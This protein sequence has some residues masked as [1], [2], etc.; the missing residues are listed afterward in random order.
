MHLRW[1]TAAGLGPSHC[2]RGE[3]TSVSVWRFGSRPRAGRIEPTSTPGP[4]FL[5]GPGGSAPAE[6]QRA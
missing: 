6:G 5:T 3:I 4:I 2:K 1:T